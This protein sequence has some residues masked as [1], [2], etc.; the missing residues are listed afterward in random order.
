MK[1]IQSCGS[2]SWGGLEMQTV[3]IA[4]ALAARGHRVTMLCVGGSTLHRQAVEAGLTAAP[5]LGGPGGKAGAALRIAAR[6]RRETWEV[7]HT[8]LSSDL[9][10]LVPGIRLARWPGR[11][12]LTKRMGSSISKKDILHRLLYRRVDNIFAISEYIRRN[13]L[14]TCPVNPEK[15]RLMHNALSLE[16]YRPELYERREIR[17]E[18]GV[19]P[20]A[21]LVGIIGRLT[22]KKGHREFLQAAEILVQRYP[23]RL[24]FLVVGGASHEEEAYEQEIRR[25]VAGNDLIRPRVFF[26]GFRSDIPRMLAAIDLLAFPSHKEA[27]GTTLLEA[28]AMGVPVVASNSGGVPDIVEPDVSGILVPPQDGHALA[29]GL[30]QLI[31]DPDLR[32]RLAQ[33]GRELVERRFRFEDY[34]DRLEGIYRESTVKE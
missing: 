18:L 22:P 14:D 6:L 11:L 25:M 34:I 24:T 19:D 20:K 8:H 9:G 32:R 4:A 29:A 26:S 21:L 30:Q 12:L 1:I 5:L 13:V 33:T 28:L 16:H 7:I 10:A 23:D 31:D 27:F 15:V 3:R 17:R 2:A